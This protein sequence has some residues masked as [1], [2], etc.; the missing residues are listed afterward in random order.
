MILESGR[1]IHFRGEMSGGKFSPV[2]PH[3]AELVLYGNK[4]HFD[5]YVVSMEP[6]VPSGLLLFTPTLDPNPTS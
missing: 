5:L 6:M 1:N 4:T 2:T 3:I